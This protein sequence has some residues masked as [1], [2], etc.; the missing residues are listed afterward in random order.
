ME[1]LEDKNQAMPIRNEHVHLFLP[2]AE[3]A[4]AQ[5]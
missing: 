2:E 1:I 4:K 5:A 3:I